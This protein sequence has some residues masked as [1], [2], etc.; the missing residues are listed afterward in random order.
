MPKASCTM[1]GAK[2]FRQIVLVMLPPP[3]LIVIVLGNIFGGLTT[4]TEA[5]DFDTVSA[6]LLAFVNKR[7]TLAAVMESTNY[8]TNLTSMVLLSRP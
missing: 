8:T 2:L 5:G 7:L 3:G 4:P 6:M 1:S